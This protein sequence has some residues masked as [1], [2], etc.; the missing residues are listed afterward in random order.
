M[1]GCDMG[2]VEIG[3]TKGVSDE[4]TFGSRDGEVR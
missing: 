2:A 4:V 1:K 3:K